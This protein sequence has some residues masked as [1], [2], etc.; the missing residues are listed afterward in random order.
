MDDSKAIENIKLCGFSLK[1]HRQ[2]EIRDGSLIKLS[3]SISAKMGIFPG[4]YFTARYQKL[5]PYVILL[6]KEPVKVVCTTLV[7]QNSTILTESVISFSSRELKEMSFSSQLK[8]STLSITHIITY[9]RCSVRHP[10]LYLHCVTPH[11]AST[12]SSCLRHAGVQGRG[13]RYQQR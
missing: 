13:W 6:R 9:N 10:C 3:S 12:H 11:Y 4:M 8:T 2:R 1:N 7:V 5:F